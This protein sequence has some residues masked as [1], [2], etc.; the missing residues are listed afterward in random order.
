MVGKGLCKYS[1]KDGKYRYRVYNFA[2]DNVNTSLM[3]KLF[4]AL[5]LLSLA[6]TAHAQVRFGIGPQGSYTL[7]TTDYHSPNVTNGGTG[8]HS[9]FAA[10][11]TAE[12]GVGHLLVRPAVLYTQKGY[13]YAYAYAA[14]GQSGSTSIRADYLTFP[15]NLGYTQHRDG[16]GVQVFGGA[17]LGC[18]TG[19]HFDN[20]VSFPSGQV[21]LYSSGPVISEKDSYVK[22]AVIQRRLDWGLQFGAGYRYRQLLAL[23]EYSIG[24]QNVDSGNYS[25]YPNYYNRGFQFSLAY[26][27]NL[28]GK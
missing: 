21:A 28:G 13:D 25:G 5:G 14:V 4:L 23:A 19:G 2:G 16:Q 3:K 17:Y 7:F 22:N 18:L 6:A 8:Y 24:L 10:G 26:L 27:F 12:F 15:L 11:L 20:T 1:F 9:G